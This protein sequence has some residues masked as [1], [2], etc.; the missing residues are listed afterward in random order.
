[1]IQI[2][3]CTVESGWTF[4]EKTSI[5]ISPPGCMDMDITASNDKV[6]LRVVIKGVCQNSDS[7]AFEQAL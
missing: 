4:K 6:S 2:G 5:Q 7:S 3:D 1:M